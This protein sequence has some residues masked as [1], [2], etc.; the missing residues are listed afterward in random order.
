MG[1]KTILSIIFI[2]IPVF[3]VGALFG[4]LLAQENS[5]EYCEAKEYKCTPLHPQWERDAIKN[6]W[7]KPSE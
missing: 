3:F 4:R 7:K 1:E 2:I 5:C 6:G